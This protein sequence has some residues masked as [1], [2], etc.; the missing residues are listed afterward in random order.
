VKKKC[1]VCGRMV[2][3]RDGKIVKHRTGRSTAN[4]V[5]PICSVSPSLMRRKDVT[6]FRPS[7]KAYNY[8]DE[9]VSDLGT[10]DATKEALEKSRS[11]TAG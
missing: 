4:N 2:G 7:G 8:V 11:E 9:M 5:K 6:N 3:I 10:S 1:S